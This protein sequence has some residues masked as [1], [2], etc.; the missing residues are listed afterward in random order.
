MTPAADSGWRYDE[1][2]PWK[3]GIFVWLA[4]G[5]LGEMASDCPGG[6]AV[7]HVGMPGVV[8]DSGDADV[9]SFAVEHRGHAMDG[10]GPTLP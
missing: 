3:G 10:A 8:V 5:C 2:P 1:V 4:G 9:G 7:R 6:S